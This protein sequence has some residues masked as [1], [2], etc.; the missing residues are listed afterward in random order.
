MALPREFTL[1]LVA[2]VQARLLALSDYRILM[3]TELLSGEVLFHFADFQSA[4]GAA[5]SKSH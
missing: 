1:A 3:N 2:Y 5:A 4:V